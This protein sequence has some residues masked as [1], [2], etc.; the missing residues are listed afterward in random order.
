MILLL[1]CLVV[2]SDQIQAACRECSGQSCRMGCL[3]YIAANIRD[4]T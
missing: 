3:L 4:R 2:L 1:I